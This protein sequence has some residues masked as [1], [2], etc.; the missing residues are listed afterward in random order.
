MHFSAIQN[1]MWSAYVDSIGGVAAE[2]FYE[3]FSFGDSAS[4]AD[5]LG[6]LVLS[7]IKRA[8]AGSVWSYEES[9]KGVPR[10]GHL[11]LVVNSA[12]EPLCIIETI[13]VDI[14]PFL[15][16][17]AEFAAIEGE[18]DGSL[19]YWRQAHTE[20]FTRECESSGRIFSEDMPVAC[21][22]FRVVFPP[23]SKNAA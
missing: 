6:Q 19:Q 3:V 11:S 20:F 10:P 17:T 23:V 21:E 8:T 13:Q 22:Q 1:A 12:A 7:G 14:R 4:M 15:G 2:D 9:D 16:V 18:G 5:E